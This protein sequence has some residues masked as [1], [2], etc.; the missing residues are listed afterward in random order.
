VHTDP[1]SMQRLSDRCALIPSPTYL[2]AGREARRAKTLRADYLRFCEP[3]HPPA[4]VEVTAT[5]DGQS[6]ARIPKD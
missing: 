4:V 2:V 5:F 6:F 3:S 1:V